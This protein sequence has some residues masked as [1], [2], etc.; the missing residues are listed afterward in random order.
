MKLGKPDYYDEF[1]CIAGACG[2]SCCIGWEIDVD[3]KMRNTYQNVSGELGERL[4]ACIDWEEGHFILQG[5]EERCPFLNRE[6]L[7]ELIIGLGEEAL[8]HI[9]R[10]H[11]RFYDWFEG[12]YTEVG[13]GL[14]CEA[15]GR[16]ILGRKEPVRLVVDEVGEPECQDE[17]VE[18]E[19][20]ERFFEARNT[21]FSI[22]QNREKSIW[23]RLEM[24]LRYTELLQEALDSESLEEVERLAHKEWGTEIIK[25][26]SGKQAVSPDQKAAVYSGILKLCREL[27]PIDESWP[28]TLD[29]LQHHISQPEQFAAAEAAMLEACSEREYE[30]EQLAVYFVYRYFMKCREDE[31]IRSRG[32][33]AVF[34]LILIRLLDTAHFARWGTLT[35]EDRVQTA[36]CCSKEI[37]YSE[38]NLEVLAD[39]FWERD[40]VSAE[41]LYLLLN[42]GYCKK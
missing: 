25:D 29:D 36:K 12:D 14:C 4:K 34:C 28:R 13:L 40:E 42:T 11:P 38:D 9:C 8:C 3:E 37:E 35:T 32:K 15:A 20:E 24:F 41:N 30:Y 16:L 33:L 7:C 19:E 23:E 31:D 5:K 17:A 10:E 21:A 26:S 6:N 18:P 27:E 1:R 22:L 2:D 39:A